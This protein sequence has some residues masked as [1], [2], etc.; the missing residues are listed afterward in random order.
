MIVDF[1]GSI[2]WTK[3][4]LKIVYVA[5]A[6]KAEDDVQFIY[7]ADRGEGYTSKLV[8]TLSILD[9]SDSDN[10]KSSLLPDLNFHGVSQPFFSTDA[11]SLYFIGLDPHATPLGIKYC[12]N[13]PTGLYKVNIDGSDLIRL[14][15][16]QQAV[17]Y[18]RPSPDG[19][20]IAFLSNPVGG[21]HAHCSSLEVLDT[22]SKE[23]ST[24]VPIID[25]PGVTDFP[26]IY[27]FDLSDQCWFSKNNQL[28]IIISSP[29]RSRDVFNSD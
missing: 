26:G 24:V 27:A 21:A 9:F 4:E 20:Y 22:K 10:I 3:D 13:R 15:Q 14:T 29:W 28:F 7:S 11:K 16:K 2:S 6:K 23:F 19:R 12:N 8:P 17:R 5:A 18:P 1:F 25:D